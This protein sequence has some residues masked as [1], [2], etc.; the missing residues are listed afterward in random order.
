MPPA[1]KVSDTLLGKSRGQ[2]IIA[3]E[4]VNWLGQSENAAQLWMFLVV[5]VKSDDVRTILHR[6][7]EC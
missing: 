5:K 4:R 7:R 6:N 2:L 1:R 3:S